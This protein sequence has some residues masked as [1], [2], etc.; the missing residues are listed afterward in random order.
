MEPVTMPER[1][2]ENPSPPSDHVEPASEFTKAHS[3]CSNDEIITYKVHEENLQDLQLPSGLGKSEHSM[4]ISPDKKSYFSKPVLRIIALLSIG[5]IIGFIVGVGV[6]LQDN[7]TPCEDGI[8][9]PSGTIGFWAK[10]GSRY[11]WQCHDRGCLEGAYSLRQ[12][13]S[14]LG[15]LLAEG[16]FAP[17]RESM[18]AWAQGGEGAELAAHCVKSRASQRLANQFF[19]CKHADCLDSRTD[20]VH[21]ECG[22]DTHGVYFQDGASKTW[23]CLHGDCIGDAVED[24]TRELFNEYVDGGV[25]TGDGGLDG[26]EID[27]AEAA[28]VCMKGPAFEP[29]QLHP[30][31]DIV[32]TS[33]SF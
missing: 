10:K 29:S 1:S 30:Q 27:L 25:R 28:H 15:L 11:E 18:R 32:I 4:T 26:T 20:G 33:G 31:K 16:E 19:G 9:G 6:L 23:V 2:Q 21:S 5:A 8:G 22:I 24:Q 12:Y 14:P 3:S 7:D 17:E 13:A